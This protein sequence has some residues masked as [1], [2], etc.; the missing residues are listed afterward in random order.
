MEVIESVNIHDDIETGAS[1]RDRS[2]SNYQ[3]TIRNL[4]DCGIKV[5][6]YNFMPVFDWMKTN[7]N[8]VLPDGSLA[9]AIDKRLE[10][11]VKRG[12]R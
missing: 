10:D 3:H 6:C 11:V 12:I 5:I 8:D 7:M 4:A 2:I 1:S 9:M